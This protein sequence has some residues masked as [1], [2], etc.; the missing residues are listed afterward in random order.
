[1]RPLLDNPNVKSW[2]CRAKRDTDWGAQTSCML[3][4]PAVNPLHEE[5]SPVQGQPLLSVIVRDVHFWI[6]LLALMA[7]LFLLHEL[8]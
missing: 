7:G 3:H 5:E 6:P 4:F 2:P 8:R 1:M